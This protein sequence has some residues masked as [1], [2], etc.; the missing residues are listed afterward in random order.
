MAT[1]TID[2]GI[3]LALLGVSA[4]TQQLGELWA[5]NATKTQQGAP[6]PNVQQAILDQA[7][8]T[9][10]ELRGVCA[11]KGVEILE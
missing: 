4:I 2:D 9:A 6:S 8:R 7:H 11:L 1:P 3:S 10:S 5:E